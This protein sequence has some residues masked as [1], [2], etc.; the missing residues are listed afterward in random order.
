MR[1]TVSVKAAKGEATFRIVPQVRNVGAGL[2]VTQAE[3]VSVTLSADVP[4]LQALTPG[5]IVAIADAQGLPAGLHAIP[6]QITPPAG[7]T[8]V[9]TEPAT[10]GV[11][12]VP[13]Q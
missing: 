3:P 2:V 10:L 12:L 5:S 11:A 13:R 6:L 9:R 4:A 7:T 1:V 8:V